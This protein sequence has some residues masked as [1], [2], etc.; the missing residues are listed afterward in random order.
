MAKEVCSDS[1]EKLDA[2]MELQL[3]NTELCVGQRITCMSYSLVHIDGQ[4][5]LVRLQTDN[6]HLFHHKQMDK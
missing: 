3:Y 6:F 1:L 4:V 2:Q 5:R